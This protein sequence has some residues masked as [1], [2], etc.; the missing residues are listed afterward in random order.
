MV[1]SYTTQH[2]LFWLLQDDMAKFLTDG[3]FLENNKAPDDKVNCK[4]V[5]EHVPNDNKENTEER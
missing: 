1:A 3:K 5:P 4:K 2:N